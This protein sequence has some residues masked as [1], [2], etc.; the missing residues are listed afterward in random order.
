VRAVAARL[1]R[2]SRLLICGSLYLAGKV[3]AENG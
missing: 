3:L 2:P 1:V